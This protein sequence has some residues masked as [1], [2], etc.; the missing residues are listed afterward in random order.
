MVLASLGCP[1]CGDACEGARAGGV[2]WD[3]VGFSFFLRLHSVG[4]SGLAGGRPDYR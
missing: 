2:L 1:V 4:A 3:M